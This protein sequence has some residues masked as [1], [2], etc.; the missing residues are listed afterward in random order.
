EKMSNW[1]KP[2]C[3]ISENLTPYLNLGCGQRFHLDWVNIDFTESG[4]GIIVHDLLQ[5]IPYPDHSFDVVY[6]SH[7]LEHF[8]KSSAKPFLDECYRV[9]RPQGILRI[10]VPDLEQIAR[11][12]LLALEKAHFGVPEWIANYEWILLEMYD[13]T[14]R[15]YSGGEMAAYLFSDT[16]PNQD[17]VLQR[18]GTEAKILIEMGRQLRQQSLSTPVATP[19]PLRF[20]KQ[21]Y[22][23]LRYSAYRR[24]ATLRV[25]LG[26]EYEVLNIG[27]FRRSGEIHQWMYDRFS[28]TSLLHQCRFQQIT[29]QAAD[30]SAIPH[31]TNFNLDTE[32]DGS[33]YK[34][35][36]I[37]IE[38]IRPDL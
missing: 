13:Q 29:Q 6:H 21:I 20:L 37:Y 26:Q 18:I 17:F 31:W 9:L 15:N 22:R 1:S 11:T 8:P 5:G 27:R 7:L 2:L 16:I 14:A 36:S 34:P 10:A 12:Y 4:K 38:A 28:L 33:V 32:P 24:E 25:L 30:T 19:Q 3:S 23:F 35:D